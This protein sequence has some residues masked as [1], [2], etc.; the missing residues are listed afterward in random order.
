MTLHEFILEWEM[1]RPANPETDYAGGLTQ[2][3]ID[4]LEEWDGTHGG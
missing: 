1:R 4:E 3:D 2:A